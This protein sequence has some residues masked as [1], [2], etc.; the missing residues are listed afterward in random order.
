MTKDLTCKEL[1]EL[2]T[3]YFELALSEGE[4]AR[5]EEHLQ[6]CGRC[7]AHVGQMQRAARAVR[8]LPREAIAPAAR[9]ELLD[10]FRLW[11]GG[12]LAAEQDYDSL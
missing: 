2:V 1:V 6:Q 9:A 8:Q 10:I 11:R 3:D 7:Q 4:R 5:F 12:A